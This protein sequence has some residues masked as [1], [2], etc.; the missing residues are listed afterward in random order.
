[1]NVDLET[2]QTGV[3]GDQTAPRSAIGERPPLI[4]RRVVVDIREEAK[5][6]AI[7][8][9]LIG[10]IE[11]VAGDHETIDEDRLRRDGRGLPKGED[12]ERAEEY[13][14]TSHGLAIY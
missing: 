3:I 2:R 12:R 4:Q 13:V 8:A 10:G 6:A 7:R 1:M 11:R 9:R 14:K 5:P